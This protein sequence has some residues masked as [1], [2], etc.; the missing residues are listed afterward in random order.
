LLALAAWL[1]FLRIKAPYYWGIDN[2]LV[3]GLQIAFMGIAALGM[4][5][6]IIGGNVDLSIGAMYAVCAT[7]A[8]IASKSMNPVAAFLLGIAV[9]G[10]IGLINGAMVWRIRISPIIITLGMLTALRGV[11]LLMTSG[12]FSVR[13]V[14]DGFKTIGQTKVLGVQSPI[15]F[16]IVGIVMTAFVL[17]RTTV[18]RHIYAIGSNRQ[19][20]AAAGLNV[21]RLVLGSFVV[22]GL[23]VGLAGVL[24]ASRLG[25]ANPGFGIGLE[26]DVITAVILGGVAFAGGEGTLGG[27]V[28]ALLLLGNVRNGLIGLG[29]DPAYTNVVTGALLIGAVALDQ[30]SQEQRERYRRRMAMRERRDT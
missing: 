22:N 7:T 3:V 30:L 5:W 19:A 25:T 11:V 15:I 17:G 4:S 13:G 20:A 29:V 28:L 10:F 6:L 21:R 27:V 23:V 16:L 1:L 14:P 2:L 18:G 9:G 8:A 24:S 12:G 26:L